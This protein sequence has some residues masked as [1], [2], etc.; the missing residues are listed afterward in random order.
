[1]Q[2]IG[3]VLRAH[4]EGAR[5]VLVNVEL[6]DFGAFVPV[7]VDV[8]ERAVGAHDG[9]RLF[10]H[11]TQAHQVFAGH[12]ELHRVA[13]RR[14]VFEPQHAPA[15]AGEL[16]AV[17]RLDQQFA[18]RLSRLQV[19]GG[20]HKLRKA[21]RRQLLVERQEKTRTAGAD[22][23]H[24]VVVQRFLFIEQRFH[25]LD[26]FFGRPERR[27]FGQFQINQHFESG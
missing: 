5:L 14:A 21:G 20:D 24:I 19:F 6:D 15:H 26:F 12:P 10:R 9:R 17:K 11:S 18:Q 25:F 8:R 2:E 7:E 23:A 3:E 16:G 13:H 4:I 27:A 22:V 1:M